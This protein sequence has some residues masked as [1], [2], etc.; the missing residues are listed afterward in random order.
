MLPRAVA[1]LLGFLFLLT[2]SRV[3]PQMAPSALYVLSDATFAE[4]FSSARSLEL[5]GCPHFG[6]PHGAPQTFGLPVSYAAS[7]LARGDTVALGSV[8][9]VYAAFLA[10]AYV[11]SIVLFRRFTT[12][13]WLALAASLLFLCSITV[14][15]FMEYGPLG[16]G[17]SLLPAYLAVDLWLLDALL[18]PT[19]RRIALRFIL[20]VAVRCL[21]IFLDGYSFLFSCALG[22]GCMLLAPLIQRRPKV[23]LAGVVLYAMA[24][25]VA[26]IAY[27][28][29]IPP[30]ALG[31]T[32]LDGFRAQGVDLY[33]LVSPQGD[34]IYHRLF[35][36][37]GDID[38]LRTYSDGASL[39]GN[40]LGI[41]WL[42]A[43]VVLAIQAIRRKPPVATAAVAVPIL[44]AGL[45]AL[46]LA[47]G[48][49]LKYKSF[50]DTPSAGFTASH[51]SMPEAA[52]VMA[53]PTAWVYGLP[54]IKT[55]RSLARWLVVTRLALAL[56]VLLAVVALRNDGRPYLAAALMGLALFE[57]IPDLGSDTRRGQVA[58][59]RAWTLNYD[60]V[61]SLERQVSASERVLFLQLHPNAGS[62]PYVVNTLCTRARL[63]C[64][65]TGGDKNMVMARRQWPVDVQ[66]AMG[67]RERA[68]AIARLFDASM[69]D[70]VVVPF[71]DLRAAAYSERRAAVDI[72]LVVERAKALARAS[73]T[74]L[75]LGERFAT[76]RPDRRKSHDASRSCGR[77]C[78]RAWPDMQV[79]V[80]NWGPRRA[81]AGG[82]IN[83]QPDGRS[84][85]WVSVADSDRDM[86]LAIGDRI[87]ATD[88]T[89][90]TLSASVP[91]PMREAFIPGARYPVFL[92]DAGSEEKL[93]LGYLDIEGPTP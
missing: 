23:A 20:V 27:R 81:V 43:L 85:M 74:R 76:L 3:L 87:L 18:K 10:A 57:I 49:S 58:Y 64:F 5:T 29:F 1:L 14:N 55:A 84:L 15:K 37:G 45:A 40:F 24:C 2:V 34:S 44:L 17:L 73:G 88:S 68:D 51:Y 38:A 35:G 30:D 25:V 71:F 52:A 16:L 8:L 53:L 61:A 83:P 33:G 54:G 63:F 72:E 36:W 41:T 65:N 70:V 22:A 80:P 4:C 66:D 62:N 91:A 50:R 90:S 26:A 39:A 77:P 21:A 9:L 75:Q 31:A 32:G 47:M 93:L 86:A 13:I 89:S 60:Y 79:P 59:G 6:F 42:V 46:V 7:L 12:S 69:M 67:N 82:E 78:W 56:L 19:R 92:I 11:G 48:P 28:G